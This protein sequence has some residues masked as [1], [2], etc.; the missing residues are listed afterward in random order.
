[1]ERK[2]KGDDRG[3]MAVAMAIVFRADGKDDGGGGE[4]IPLS[5]F[6]LHRSGNGDEVMQLGRVESELGVLRT[7][8]RRVHASATPRTPLLPLSCLLVG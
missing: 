3:T 6:G 5:R 4:A 7:A 8:T 1:M 2:W